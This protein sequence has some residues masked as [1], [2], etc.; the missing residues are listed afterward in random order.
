MT[1]IANNKMRELEDCAICQVPMDL[2]ATHKQEIPTE[3]KCNHVFHDSCIQK[4]LEHNS[5]CPICRQLIGRGKRIRIEI[6]ES[7]SRTYRL[8]ILIHSTTARTETVTSSAIQQSAPFYPTRGLHFLRPLSLSERTHRVTAR[9]PST[10][11]RTRGLAGSLSYLRPYDRL[12]PFG[13]SAGILYGGAGFA[14]P[15]FTIAAGP[16]L[17]IGLGIP[18]L[19]VTTCVWFFGC[20]YLIG[21]PPS[22]RESQYGERNV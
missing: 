10:S 13:G 2:T 14:L 11:P 1:N 20:T 9:S 12:I 7:S 19:A 6:E 4:W 3:L 16:N 15:A 18:L 22:R 21:E 8:N 17:G 5:T